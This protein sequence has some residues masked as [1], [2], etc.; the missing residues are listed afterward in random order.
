M[1]RSLLTTFST[2]VFMF[3]VTSQANAT[4]IVQNFSNSWSGD[5]WNYNGYVAAIEWQYQPYTASTQVITSVELK[6]NIDVTGLTI[7][8]T[9][10]TR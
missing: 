9:F 4:S 8:D 6:M 2:L 1:K 3:I 7:G 5:I 10:R